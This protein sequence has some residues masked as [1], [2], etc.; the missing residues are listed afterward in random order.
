VAT[1]SFISSPALMIEPTGTF[2]R[3]LLK[4]MAGLKE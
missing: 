4:D 2:L 1:E 3:I